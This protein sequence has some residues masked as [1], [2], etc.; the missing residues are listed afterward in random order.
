MREK[1]Q[2]DVRKCNICGEVLNGKG[3]YAICTELVCI[4]CYSKYSYTGCK[5]KLG[6]NIKTLTS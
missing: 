4:D 3:H 1:Q 5:R 2:Q 6:L